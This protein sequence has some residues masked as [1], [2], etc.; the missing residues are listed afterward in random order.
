TFRELKKRGYSFE[1]IAPNQWGK[2]LVCPHCGESRTHYKL[3][4]QEPVFQKRERINMGAVERKRILALLNNRDAFT[5]ATISSVAEIDHKVP[6]SRLD[7]DIDARSL[8]DDEIKIHFQL[9]TREHN[10]LKDRACGD[11]KTSNVRPPLF[12]IGFWYEGDERYQGTCVGCGWYDG[13]K[14]RS[15]I[16]KKF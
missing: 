9:L 5:G 1:E 11:C 8:S 7:R 15:E 2:A 16:N 3:L 14:W 12:E 6:W 4:E 10:L 13:A